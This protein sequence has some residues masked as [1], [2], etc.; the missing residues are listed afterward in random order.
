MSTFLKHLELLCNTTFTTKPERIHPYRRHSSR[1]PG[2]GSKFPHVDEGAKDR[3]RKLIET[4][5]GDLQGVADLSMRTYWM[6]S[7][8]FWKHHHSMKKR[9]NRYTKHWT[10]SRRLCPCRKRRIILL[11]A[12]GDLYEAVKESKSAVVGDGTSIAKDIDLAFNDL[13]ARY[14]LSFLLST[15]NCF[16]QDA[17]YC[18][19]SSILENPKE[20]KI[21]VEPPGR[22][23]ITQSLNQVM[24]DLLP[25][26]WNF[27]L[28][29]SVQ[30]TPS[31]PDWGWWDQRDGHYDMVELDAGEIDISAGF[32]LK[33]HPPRIRTL[34]NKVAKMSE[35][36][37]WFG[38][39]SRPQQHHGSFVP[40]TF[41][42]KGI[43]YVLRRWQA[44]RAKQGRVC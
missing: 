3:I 29:Q 31:K 23:K 40:R 25:G 34:G 17:P 13:T 41:D 43:R 8:G 27:R 10:D 5:Q 26:T 14:Y 15:A 44:K 11:D 2:V 20:L 33:V 24:R 22:R 28:A 7:E 19:V 42:F 9:L 36:H 30:V 37:G 1:T 16:L 35:V 21:S 12:L 4:M 39:V 18:F 32:P 38:W 6:T